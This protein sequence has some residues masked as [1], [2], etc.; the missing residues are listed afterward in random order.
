MCL[1]WSTNWVFIFQMA[2]LTMPLIR[3]MCEW[4]VL[5]INRDMID[6][7]ARKGFEDPQNVP[8]ATGRGLLS[9][10]SY[11]SCKGCY[12]LLLVASWLSRVYRAD[13]LRQVLF[14]GQQRSPLPVLHS[15]CL[16][17]LTQKC[18]VE[19]VAV[20]YICSGRLSTRFFTAV[21][22]GSEW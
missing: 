12:L 9:S 7:R 2:L 20:G 1:L 5:L 13:L 19:I 3:H 11:W 17:S 16:H 8:I 21:V 10:K 14:L 4:C 15:A 18:D 22:K 6:L